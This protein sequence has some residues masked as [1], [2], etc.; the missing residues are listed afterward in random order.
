MRVIFEAACIG[1]FVAA[2]IY[3]TGVASLYCN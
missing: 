2:G 1:V 3:W